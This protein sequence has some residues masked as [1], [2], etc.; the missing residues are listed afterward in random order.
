MTVA[1]QRSTMPKADAANLVHVIQD[2]HARM[3]CM[4]TALMQP[5]Q[6]GARPCRLRPV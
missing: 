1:V 4:A 5:E 3:G 2:M 6:A